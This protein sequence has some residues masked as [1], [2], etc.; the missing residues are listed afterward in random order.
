MMSASTSPRRKRAAC[1]AAALLGLGLSLG[2]C[3]HDEPMS[4]LNEGIPGDYRLRHPI[5]VEEANQSI[6]VFVGRGRGGSSAEQRADVMGVAQSWMHG[7]PGMV[8]RA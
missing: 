6:V 2:G 5:A 4:S 3:M 1:L 7:G 8:R